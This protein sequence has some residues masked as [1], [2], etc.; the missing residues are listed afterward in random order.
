MDTK[1]IRTK[2][3]N[4]A[5]SILGSADFRKYAVLLP[6]I[7]KGDAIHVLFEIRSQNLRRQPGE[8]CFPGGRMENKDTSFQDTALRET[9]EELGISLKQ[10]SDVYPLDYVV[11]PFGM[12][13]HP[14]AGMIT[15]PEIINPNPTEVAEVFTVPLSFF[16]N[17][18]PKYHYVYLQMVPEENFPFELIAGGQNYNWRTGKIEELFYIYDDKVIWGLTAKIL[19]HFI[20]VLR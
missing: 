10:I 8:I 20:D 5:P 3:G 13:I 1:F 6:L 17:T 7:Q 12:I 14:F 2:L 9:T 18:S 16:Q 15:N 11:S 19:S 4:H